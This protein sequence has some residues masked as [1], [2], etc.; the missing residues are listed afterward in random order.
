MIHLLLIKLG[1]ILLDERSKSWVEEYQLHRHRKDITILVSDDFCPG[2]G[3]ESW[4]IKALAAIG[5][6]PKACHDWQGTV[7]VGMDLSAARQIR[8]LLR[9]A[10]GDP[11]LR[12]SS[13]VKPSVEC[14][15]AVGLGFPEKLNR[16]NYYFKHTFYWTIWLFWEP[17]AWPAIAGRR[18][19][20]RFR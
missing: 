8:T 14:V 5:R 2:T 20:E 3:N 12:A 17:R 18:G 7:A 13:T 15:M 16:I 10:G 11:S 1:L 9:V 19:W 4:L 6:I